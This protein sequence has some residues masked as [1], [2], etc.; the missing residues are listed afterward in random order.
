MTGQP[1]SPADQRAYEANLK[2]AYLYQF[3][4]NFQLWWP[5]WV[6]YL[7]DKR[8]LSLTQ[9]TALDSVF[10]LIIVVAQVP[11]GAVA[12]R[13]G[14]RSA[15]ILASLFL[16]GGIAVFGLA[17]SYVLILISYAGWGLGLAFQY[18]GDSAFLF[19]T[20]RMLGRPEEFQKVYGRYWGVASVGVIGGLLLGAPMAAATDLSLPI[21]V[22][23]GIALLATCAALSFREPALSLLGP[24]A[25]DLDERPAEALGSGSGLSFGDLI[26]ESFQLAYRQ[27][28]VRCALLY[29]GVLGVS[30]FVPIVFIQPF[31]RAHD[32][33][34]GNLGLFQVPMR[35][36]AIVG[37]LGAYRVSAVLGERQTL[38][39]M[40]VLLMVGYAVL[41][42]WDASYAYV[43]FPVVSLVAMMAN[44]VVAD[45]LNRR[46]PSERRATILSIRQL[47]FSLLL[48]PIAPALG[49]MADEVSLMGAFWASA[50]LVAVP[51]PFIF[52]AWWRAEAREPSPELAVEEAAP[53][54]E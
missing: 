44:P 40:P 50:L 29:G 18:G 5:I 8:G 24:S 22:S 15:L 11:A 12:D 46:I 41:G 1:L 25:A 48:V 21:V 51:M 47:L 23:G 52:A 45:Y 38:V 2:K 17:D 9:V 13:W 7:T 20:L 16:A 30:S 4:M 6:V 34:V 53:A 49:F 31:L 54:G 32:V 3:F 39:V 10:W 37:A 42:S 14:R 28:R 43:A 27:P 26:R 36:L 35:V 19:D 33:S